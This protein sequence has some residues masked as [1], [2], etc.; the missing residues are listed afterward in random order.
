M[1]PWLRGSVLSLGLLL[2]APGARAAVPAES[3][4]SKAQTFQGALRL[5]RVDLGYEVLEKDAEAGYL[6]FRGRPAGKGAAPEGSIE[7]IDRR[8]GVRVFVRLVDQPRYQE[9]LLC[10]RLL[11]KLSSDYGDPPRRD[12]PPRDAQKPAAPPAKSPGS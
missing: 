12:E 3:G 4:Y 9:Q 11:K 7:V 6:L 2:A 1:A 5:L 8:D 10:D